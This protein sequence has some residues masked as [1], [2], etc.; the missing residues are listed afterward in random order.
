MMTGYG[1]GPGFPMMGGWFG[2]ALMLLFWLLVIA[3][4]VLLV[5]WVV[6]ATGP[7][8]HADG[9]R[10]ASPPAPPADDAVSIARRRLASGEIT[11]EE[12]E[13]LVRVLGG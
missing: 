8:T 2:G 12:Y 9:G 5:V 7:G 1:T 4:L 3:G 6:R 11:T 13:T 10:P